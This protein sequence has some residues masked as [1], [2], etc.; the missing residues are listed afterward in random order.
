MRCHDHKYDPLPQQDY[1][2]LAASL[3]QTAHGPI[4]L[5]PDPAATQRALEQHARDHEVRLA[6]WRDFAAKELPARFTKWQQEALPKLDLEPRWQILDV[7]SVRT[8]GTWLNTSDEGIVRFVGPHRRDG[9]KYV[10]TTQTFQHALTSLRLEALT[11]KSL[12]SRGPG[13]NGN[14]SFALGDFKVTATPLDPQNKA[15][16]IILKLK[17]ILAAFEE[18]AQ[19]LKNAVDD[20]PGTFWRANADGGKDNAAIFEIEGGLPGFAGGTTLTFELKLNDAGLGRFRLAVS[21]VA[22]T[23]TWAG[24]Q[25]TQHLGEIK[26]ILTANKNVLP[27]TLRE[28]TVRWFSPF[29]DATRTVRLAVD[30]HARAQP[31]P[32]L[33]EVYTTIAGGQD[34][35]LLRRG[36]VD[37]K[38]GKATP[39]VLQV[40]SRNAP[41]PAAT[42]GAEAKPTETEPRV[43]LANWMTDVDHGA[44]PLVAR[45]IVNRLWQHHLGEGIVSTPNDFGAQGDRPTHPELLDHLANE[46][47]KGGWKLKPIHKQIMLSATYQQANT[48]SPENLK[49]DP[50]NRFLW[51]YKPQRLEAE[52]I[53]DALL[54]VG[55]SL[56]PA[57]YGPSILDNTPRRSVYLRV[58]RSE[59]IPFMTVFDAPEPT[60]SIGTRIGTTVP[61]Q[62]LTMLNSPF[63]RLQAEKLAA[64]IKPAADQPLE[65]AI[66]RAYQMA[67]SRASNDAERQRMLAFLQA[68]QAALG[69]TPADLDKALIEFCQ[70]L[71]CLNEFVYVD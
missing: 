65:S 69:A 68:Q 64:R 55:G 27:D 40:L 53:R 6:A 44:G 51:Y 63:V 21:T 14:G 7:L 70:V 28:A 35:F 34:V 61:T 39:G 67:F 59:L 57:M 48:V 20:N 15:A 25:V 10:V 42:A 2:A 46:L 19:P 5:D 23:P 1:Y 32:P 43:A 62:A 12:P 24:E 36:E 11:H 30:E 8:D 60:Q 54:A 52:I 3:A 29:D 4:N 47:I 71:L 26:A 66:D 58:K 41:A 45:L 33:T 49:I 18:T 13:L 31:R 56:D 38:Q 37:N 50:A 9:D 16:P 22:G 17:P